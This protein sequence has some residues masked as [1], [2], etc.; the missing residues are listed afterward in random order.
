MFLPQKPH[1]RSPS[2]NDLANFW[3]AF[4]FALPWIFAP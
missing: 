1:L 4:A 2:P 3:V